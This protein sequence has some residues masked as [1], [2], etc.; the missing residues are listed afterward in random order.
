MKSSPVL[1]HSE[2]KD[3]SWR[4]KPY[5]TDCFYANKRKKNWTKRRLR[6]R[7]ADT[8]ACVCVRMKERM[9]DVSESICWRTLVQYVYGA[10]RVRI[11]EHQNRWAIQSRSIRSCAQW[12]FKC[13]FNF[14]VQSV[15][16]SVY[17]LFG[18]SAIAGRFS[19]HCNAT[20]I[21]IE[22]WEEEENKKWR[23]L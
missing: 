20:Y 11:V 13:K 23:V 2:S 8:C 12:C 14:A 4:E 9:N 10:F 3:W 17:L 5:K 21:Y 18:V 7:S 1:S 22:Q 6:R 16:F 15:F 19:A